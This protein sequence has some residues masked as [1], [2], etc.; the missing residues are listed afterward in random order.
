M[1][2]CDEKLKNQARGRFLVIFFSIIL[3]LV[4]YTIVDGLN[5]APGASPHDYIDYMT[6]A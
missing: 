5:Y 6:I 3:L 2:L 1:L 4:V